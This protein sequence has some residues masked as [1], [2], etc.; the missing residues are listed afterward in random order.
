MLVRRYCPVI[1]HDIVTLFVFIYLYPV[2][3][4]LLEAACIVGFNHALP[5]VLG[6]AR[7]VCAVQKH[8]NLFH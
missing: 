5:F 8:M 2:H 7:N 3:I 1:H 4:Q 6:D